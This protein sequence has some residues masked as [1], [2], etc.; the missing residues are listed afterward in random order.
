MAL[1]YYLKKARIPFVVLEANHR[2]GGRIYTKEQK[3]CAPLEIGATWLG[4]QHT[5]LMGLLSELGI[6]YFEQELGTQAIYEPISTSPA[7]LV[8]LPT[9]EAPSYR[10]KDGTS[11]II[12][13]L[14]TRIGSEHIH[15]HQPVT[16]IHCRD[17]A[18]IVRCE[19][20][21]YMG[22]KVVSTLPLNLLASRIEIKP[23]L[24]IELIQLMQQTH[25]WMGESIKLALCFEHPFWRA[26]D[27]SGTL[28]SNVGPITELYD[29]S[30]FEGSMHALKGFI[31]PSYAT[32][33]KQDRLNMVLQQLEKY[34]GP[35]V[36]S[37]SNYHEMVWSAQAYTYAAY[38]QSVVPHQN[39]GAP[40]FQQVWHK[41]R[42]ILAGS[43]TAP[44]F[45][46][47]MEGAVRSAQLA[48]MK[49]R[50]T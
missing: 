4:K 18:C 17:K 40:L 10:I 25:T 42:F 11:G 5:E 44:Q 48:L 7:Q 6:A 36:H 29:N 19:Q 28:F 43:E 1:A 20:Q 49:L 33:S 32:L 24:P 27:T 12:K 9:N 21:T 34:Y 8:S 3:D 35:Q 45:P 13:E 37:F 23:A 22:N 26:P 47:S 2:L 15:M 46:G 14:V 50:K 16:A 41:N 30:N 39:N 31:N 38:K